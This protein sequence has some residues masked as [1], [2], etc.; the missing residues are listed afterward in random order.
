[1]RSKLGLFT[2]FTAWRVDNSGFLC[3]AQGAGRVLPVRRPFTSRAWRRDPQHF[4]C[5]RTG[6]VPFCTSDPHVYAH[7]RSAVLLPGWQPAADQRAGACV[8]CPP[9]RTP[10]PGV[11]GIAAWMGSRRGWDRA[12]RH[13]CSPPLYRTGGPCIHR[14]PAGHAHPASR[15]ARAPRPVTVR[16]ALPRPRAGTRRGDPVE[17]QVPQPVKDLARTR[18]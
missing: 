8:T 18:S 3:H 10:G 16:P 14:P 11:D 7:S 17:R 1:M 12:R 13:R 15:S 6:L 5:A 9:C 4:H 2:G